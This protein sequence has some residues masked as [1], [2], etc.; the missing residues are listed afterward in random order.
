MYVKIKYQSRTQAVTVGTG[1]ASSSS[2]RLEDMA[3][4]VVA[5]S[6]QT[7]SAT[8]TVWGSPDDATFAVLHG[9]DGAAATL[10]IPST[11]AVVAMPD[12]VYGTRFVRL[13]SDVSLSTA[14]TVIV[15]AKS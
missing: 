14:A 15:A 3:A 12:A 8:L 10:T 13:T 2:A 11:P 9:S 5:V 6:G 7:A 1:T 4:A